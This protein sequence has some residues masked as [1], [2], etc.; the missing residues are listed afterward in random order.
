MKIA[1][2]YVRAISV[3]QVLPDSQLGDNSS[4][5]KFQEI[6]KVVGA[7]QSFHAISTPSFNLGRRIPF[8]SRLQD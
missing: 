8:V 1:N 6:W 5:C 3:N 7:I 4:P 2:R